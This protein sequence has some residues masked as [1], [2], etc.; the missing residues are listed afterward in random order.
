M[1]VK[2]ALS[3]SSSCACDNGPGINTVLFPTNFPHTVPV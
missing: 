1:T 2:A 3:F